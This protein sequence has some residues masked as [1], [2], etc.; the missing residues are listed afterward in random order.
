MT[1]SRRL[2]PAYGYQP[3]SDRLLIMPMSF[4]NSATPGKELEAASRDFSSFLHSHH[5]ELPPFFFFNSFV[6]VDTNPDTQVDKFPPCQTRLHANKLTPP[7]TS[8]ILTCFSSAIHHQYRMYSCTS[9]LCHVNSH[10]RLCSYILI[11]M[12]KATTIS[13]DGVS[14]T[15]DLGRS[16]IYLQHSCGRR[17]LEST[18]EIPKTRQALI[19]QYGIQCTVLPWGHDTSKYK[20][21]VIVEVQHDLFMTSVCLT[22]HSQRR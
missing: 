7:L 18:K 5:K 6:M 15:R 11:D 17:G 9:V 22:T 14:Y 13:F 21:C 10:D 4:P 1:L 2:L 8:L 20:H 12:L 16:N 19:I 3:L